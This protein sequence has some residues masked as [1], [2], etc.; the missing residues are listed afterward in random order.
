MQP[1]VAGIAVGISHGRTAVEMVAQIFAFREVV[2]NT[3]KRNKTEWKSQSRAQT[4]AGVDI[5]QRCVVRIDTITST[6][7]IYVLQREAYVEYEW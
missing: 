1:S 3:G 7:E 2:S 5:V 4:E 6:F